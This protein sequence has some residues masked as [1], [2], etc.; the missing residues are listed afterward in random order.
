[1]SS[2]P[3]IRNACLGQAYFLGPAMD[4]STVRSAAIIPGHVGIVGAERG[5]CG[6]QGTITVSSTI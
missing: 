1:M 6:I 3:F 2:N 4:Q 5:S